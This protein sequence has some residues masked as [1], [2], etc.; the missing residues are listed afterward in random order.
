MNDKKI[1]KGVKIRP[2]IKISDERGA[3]FRMLRSDDPEFTNFGEIYFSLIYPG[4]IK[5]WHLHLKMTLHFAVIS[6]MIKLVLYDGRRNSSTY[7]NLA[8]LYIGDQNFVLVTIPPNIWIGFKGIGT[9]L[10]IVSDCTDM[11]HDPR[12]M[13]RMDP[14]DQSIIK[15]D[16][17]LQHK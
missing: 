15:Y 4:V 14:F 12:E 13:K 16:W 2:L 17:S 6:G 3:I 7:K 9:E 10:S 11:S 5:G 1:I 8:E